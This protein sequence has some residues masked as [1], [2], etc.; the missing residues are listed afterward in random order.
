M[1]LN[2][3]LTHIAAQIHADPNELIAYAQEDDLGGFHVDPD[4]S[5]FPMGSLWGVE[6]Q[7]LYAL[8]RHLKP[9]T[10]VE[11]GGWAGASASHFA[12]AVI[13]NGYGK[14]ISVDNHVGGMDHGHLLT[15]EFRKYVTLINANGQDWLRQQPNGSIGLLFEDADHSTPLVAELSS[16]GLQKLAPGGILANHD[17]AHDFYHDGNSVMALRN[18]VNFRPATGSDVGRAVRDGLAQ[19]NAHFTP[20]LAAPSD[21]GLAITVNPGEWVAP[22]SSKSEAHSKIV[23]EPKPANQALTPEDFARALQMVGNANIESVSEPPTTPEPK[24]EGIKS[25]HID[26]REMAELPPGLRASQNKKEAEPKPKTTRSHKAKPK[27]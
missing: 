12:L 26:M 20:Y 27:T 6:G 8:T 21:C 13:A 14:I 24:K 5:R 17:A 4:Q 10:I 23:K 3:V 7:I 1:E 2:E 25:Q 15:D 16:L 22:R 9:E 19:A 11:I 18:D